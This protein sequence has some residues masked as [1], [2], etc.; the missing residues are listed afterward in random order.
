MTSRPSQGAR[1][2][3][4]PIRVLFVCL[5][6]ICRSPAAE[7]MFLHLLAQQGLEERFSVDSAGT[8]G[9]HVGRPADARMRAAAARRGITLTSRAR[10]LEPSDLRRFDHI[11]TMDADNLAAVQDLARREGGSSA[12]ITPMV[13]HCRRFRSE[14]V[15]DPYYGG[16]HGFEHVLD[17]L[18]DACAGLL[19]TLWLRDDP[20]DPQDPA[21]PPG[22][23]GPGTDPPGPESRPPHP[24]RR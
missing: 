17:L 13:Q 14:E 12:T 5:G 11:L 24:S 10:Q 9:W 1:A 18:E 22:E 3:G 7:G 8:G 2:A 15:P 16:E 19:N 23:P 21:R 6:N 4:R 20:T